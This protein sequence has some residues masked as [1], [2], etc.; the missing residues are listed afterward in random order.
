MVYFC[1]TI[2]FYSTC[3]A[4]TI[5]NYEGTGIEGSHRLFG[6]GTWEITTKRAKAGTHSLKISTSGAGW[7]CV[8]L[9]EFDTTQNFSEYSSI[10]YWLKATGSIKEREV[11]ISLKLAFENGSEWT[12]KTDQQQNLDSSIDKWKKFSVDFSDKNF[13]KEG[14]K[15]SHDHRLFTPESITKIG[16]IVVSVQK[17]VDLYIDDVLLAAKNQPLPKPAVKTKPVDTP[18]SKKSTPPGVYESFT[19]LIDDFV[20]IDKYNVNHKNDVKIAQSN[21]FGETGTTKTGT[22]PELNHTVESDGILS[23]SWSKE[24]VKWVTKLAAEG[25]DISSNKYLILRMKSSNPF[26]KMS[27]VFSSSSGEQ[28][29]IK[30][31]TKSIKTKY[32]TINLPLTTLKT[33]ISTSVQTISLVFHDSSGT[34]NLNQIGL[35]DCK[36]P[37]LIELNFPGGTLIN[38][39]NNVLIEV[40]LLDEFGF[41]CS[42]FNSFIQLIVT[43]GFIYP[44]QISGFSNGK[45]RGIFTISGYGN[46]QLI[47]KDIISGVTDDN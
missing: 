29:S 41:P 37:S 30:I 16:I 35:S 8:L 32:A 28:D 44:S 42:D 24:N 17:A 6:Y 9:K 36:R 7:G 20:P 14:P 10:S 1:L 43:E 27:A 38:P 45:A 33:S 13:T 26:T 39:G 4:K 3:H 40:I 46:Q 18:I 21:S 12:Q 25:V 34:A 22:S 31:P 15:A 19:G 5:D 47:A 23:L 11:T 2:T